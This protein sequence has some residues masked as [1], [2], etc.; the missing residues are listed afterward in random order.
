[1]AAAGGAGG[2]EGAGGLAG[3]AGGAGWLTGGA[4]PYVSST[5]RVPEW[6]LRKISMSEFPHS[7]S[8]RGFKV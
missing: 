6:L 5:A 4:G 7:S 8:P 3:G 2:Q 1:M